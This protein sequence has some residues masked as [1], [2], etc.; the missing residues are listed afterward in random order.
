M[1]F[2]PPNKHAKSGILPNILQFSKPKLLIALQ[3]SFK[4]N[5]Q[6]ENFFNFFS[7]K[8]PLQSCLDAFKN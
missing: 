6:I 4:G 2:A 3:I 5:L 8:K 7:K 1:D